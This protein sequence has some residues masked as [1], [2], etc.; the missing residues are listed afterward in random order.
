MMSSKA[1]LWSGLGL[2]VAILVACDGADGVLGNP[3]AQFG[4]F[5]LTAFNVPANGTP[6]PTDGEQITYLG[7]VG[8]NSSAQPVDF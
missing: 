2:S 1:K 5:F 6:L 3:A 4:T 7:V 8:V